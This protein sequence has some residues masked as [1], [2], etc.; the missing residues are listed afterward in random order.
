MSGFASPGWFVMLLAV[1]AIGM[2]YLLAQRRRRKHIVRFANLELLERVMPRRP[3]WPRHVAPALLL[4][5]LTAMMIGLAGPTAEARVP[6]NRAVV[7]LTIDVSLSMTAT[8]IKPSRVEAAKAA[9]VSFVE[10]LTPGVN[11]GLVTFGGTATVQVTPTTERAPVVEAIKNMRLLPGTATGDA[12]AASLATID[13]F[14]KMLGDAQGPPPSRIVLMSDG[15]QTVGRDVFA[16]ADEA[17]K[18]HI[19]ITSISFGTQDGVVDIE[20]RPIPVPA[21]TPAMREIATIS[22]GDFF[23]AASAERIREVYDTLGEQIGYETK[24]GDASKPWFAVAALLT[25]AAAATG[26]AFTRRLP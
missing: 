4:V 18:A 13:Q 24:R 20:G 21:D 3:G 15:K 25:T 19:P 12:V 17:K 7:M 1:A 26:L 9:A 2:G 10:G 8:D 22:G 23:E 6:R 14:G 16:A 5:G 11:L